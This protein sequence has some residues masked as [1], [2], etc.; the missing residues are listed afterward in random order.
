VLFFVWGQRT[1]DR[2]LSL[3]FFFLLVFS[4]VAFLFPVFHLL[5]ACNNALAS[6][7]FIGSPLILT[8]VSWMCMLP[9]PLGRGGKIVQTSMSWM[10]VYPGLIVEED[11]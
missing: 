5:F 4:Y 6:M 3:Y 9:W 10:D 7:V 2:F 1:Y 8:C 11:E